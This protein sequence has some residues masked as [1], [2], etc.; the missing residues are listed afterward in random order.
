MKKIIWIIV[1]AVVVFIG[2]VLFREYSTKNTAITTQI[3]QD[4]IQKARE[5]A[6]QQ[7]SQYANS[8]QKG[9]EALV[10]YNLLA[11]Q[12]EAGKIFANTAGYETLCVNGELNDGIPS[13]KVHIDEILKME[14]V[15][16]QKSADIG[17]VSSS[18]SYAISIQ[19]DPPQVFETVLFCVDSTGYNGKGLLNHDQLL[20][21]I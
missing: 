21:N 3:S 15:S 8:R 17:C 16:D 19:V 13:I 9:N 18:K 11:L 4:E 12:T 14:G 6:A 1:F 2:G 10:K 5:Y 20:C 7:A